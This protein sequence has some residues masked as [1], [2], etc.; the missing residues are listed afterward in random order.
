MI[1]KD[2]TLTKFGY[3]YDALSAGSNKDIAVNCDYCGAEYV[4]TNKR[5]GI[6]RKKFES[7]GLIKDC[8]ANCKQLKTREAYA[9]Q[10]KDYERTMSDGIKRSHASRSEEDKEKAIAKNKETWATKTQAELDNIREKRENT[11]IEKYGS[12]DNYHQQTYETLTE[13]ML[14]KYG[15]LNPS[16][17]P[18]IR[19]KRMNTFREK[20]GVDYAGQIPEVK[21]KIAETHKDRYGGLFM[22]QPHEKDGYIAKYKENIFAI[23]QKTIQTNLQKYGVDHH[24]KSDYCKNR[25]KRTR[26][27]NETQYE[28]NGKTSD[29]IAAETGYAR[30]YVNFL[31]RN[32]HDPYTLSRNVTDIES[33]VKLILDR[34]GL[35]Y[36]SHKSVAGRKTDFIV[37]EQLVVEADGLYFHSE[38][39]GKEK[40]YH[41]IK[42]NHY[43]KHGYKSLFFRT[44]EIFERAPVLESIVLNNLNKSTH[45][46]AD[47][48]KIEP[49][50]PEIARKFFAANSF[51]SPNPE[52]CIGLVRNNETLCAL[53]LT[54]ANQ[55]SKSYR[56][57]KFCQKNQ[58]NVVGGFGKL[59]D[60]IRETY[61]PSSLVSY[62][63]LRYSNGA[64]LESSDFI[65]AG[66]Y[67]SFVWTNGRK[68]FNRNEY[69]GNTGYDHNLTKIWDCG[70]AKY[71][72]TFS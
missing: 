9:L 44:S 32:K 35:E 40:R 14:A 36:T 53:S 38:A 15:V 23:R 50:E 12:L 54:L 39:N 61:Q 28:I 59:V 22:N 67:L 30:G 13:T 4:T 41:Q 17:S 48:C 8:C 45:V 25:A 47:T 70:Q 60:Y 55:S 37:C 16:Q 19:Q 26:I 52:N 57:E 7:I 6:A 31:I 29:M 42:R 64:H 58:H 69:R 56:I 34:N 2:I 71:I 3:S 5:Y 65:Y 63:D 11:A 20:Y 24:N 10:G 51:S 66:E 18:E 49:L 1:N 68:V 46:D 72:K 33:I 62:I 43:L 27:E 21:A